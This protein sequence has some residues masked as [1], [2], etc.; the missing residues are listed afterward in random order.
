MTALES[1]AAQA[2]ESSMNTLLSMTLHTKSECCLNSV[3]K[4][5]L[6]MWMITHKK[7]IREGGAQIVSYLFS[8]SYIDSDNI[9]CAYRFIMERALK[10]H[11]RSVTEM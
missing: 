9:D 6:D 10:S 3:Q 7:L 4:C 5:H 2:H 1:N 11:T 8:S